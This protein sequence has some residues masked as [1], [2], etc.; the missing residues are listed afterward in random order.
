LRIQ[1]TCTFALAWCA[2]SV[3]SE[4]S[5]KTAGVCTPAARTTE[6]D[7]PDFYRLDAK[8]FDWVRERY[9]GGNGVDRFNIRFA[10]PLV[11]STPEN[12]TVYG[13][14]F[15]PEGARKVPCVIVLHIAGGDFPLAR[16]MAS[17]LAHRGVA[18]LF[19]K[20]PY[21]G[22][23]RPP[24]GRVRLIS[25]NLEQGLGGMR[26]AVLDLRRACD[27]I[28]TQPDLDAD[29]CGVMG[30]SL[31]AIVGGL[32]SAVEPRL[33]H[34][35]LIMGAAEL[36]HILYESK[37]RQAKSLLQSW[38]AWGGTREILRTMLKPIDVA[39]YADRLAKRNVI[40]FTATNDETVPPKCGSALW[41][42]A[43]KPRNVCYS[44]GHYTM[45]W[46][47]PWVLKESTDFFA[48]WPT[49][50]LPSLIQEK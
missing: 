7:V 11:T 23:R 41:I 28:A 21:Y 26:Q 50:R 4:P 43:G 31:G 45:A 49:E 30:V 17:T 47:L 34:A 10:S 33:S 24:T 25:A 32:A 38:T 6:S 46:R 5:F 44:C 15:R 36:E 35:C 16:F 22:E 1:L 29:R 39:T 8:P 20:L 3:A 37:E 27:W 2:S 13:E 19:I 42:A 40:M 14:L 18:G 48:A 9:R 12:N